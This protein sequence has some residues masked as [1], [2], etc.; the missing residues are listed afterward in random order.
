[1]K[2]RIIPTILV[3]YVAGCG[4]VPLAFGGWMHGASGY[5]HILLL[6]LL[7]PIVITMSF[8]EGYVDPKFVALYG[9]EIVAAIILIALGAKKGMP[10][11]FLFGL[12]LV[13][14]IITAITAYFSI[15]IA[16]I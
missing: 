1:M 5:L 4:V 7:S 16:L 12:F 14:L 3:A 2:T 8:I 13:V 9:F 10:K 6:A 15:E 11:P